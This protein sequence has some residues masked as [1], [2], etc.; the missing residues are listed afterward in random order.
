MKSGS[1]A[2][3]KRLKVNLG[4]GIERGQLGE[5]PLELKRKV[6]HV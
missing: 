4:P 5:K 6:Q 2:P 1:R 3:G